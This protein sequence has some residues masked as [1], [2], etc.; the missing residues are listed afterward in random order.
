[1]TKRKKVFIT[2]LIVLILV[3]AGTFYYLFFSG[4]LGTLADLVTGPNER[5]VVSQKAQEIF[6]NAKSKINLQVKNDKLVLED[7]KK[8]G[9]L[10]GIIDVGDF[11]FI[12][13][14]LWEAEV[15]K[16]SQ[17]N[18]SIKTSTD[19]QTWSED[20][21]QVSQEDWYYINIRKP[22]SRIMYMVEFSK[23]K[24]T[25]GAD[26]QTVK[27]QSNIYLDDMNRDT[28]HRENEDGTIR[29]NLYAHLY[30]SGVDN[31][32]Y[33]GA[34]IDNAGMAS[35]KFTMILLTDKMAF[36]SPVLKTKTSDFNNELTEFLVG[37][38]IKVYFVDEA[39]TNSKKRIKG[40]ARLATR[41]W[42][43]DQ[44]EA[45]M[46]NPSR[47]QEQ[48]NYLTNI[49]DIS[50]K[51]SD[52]YQKLQIVEGQTSVQAERDKKEPDLKYL[53]SGKDKPNKWQRFTAFN[54]EAYQGKDSVKEL[55]NTSRMKYITK[56]QYIDVV[57]NDS[58][59]KLKVNDQLKGYYV[60]SGVN[61]GGKFS[62]IFYPIWVTN[63]EAW[64]GA[65]EY[66]RLM[67][68]IPCKGGGD[69]SLLAT[70]AL[71]QFGLDVFDDIE[72]YVADGVENLWG[73]DRGVG[74][75]GGV[76]DIPG[77]E[78]LSDQLDRE[79]FLNEGLNHIPGSAII[80]E[81]DG[82][83]IDN[84]DNAG[85]GLENPLPIPNSTLN[86]MYNIFRIVEASNPLIALGTIFAENLVIDIADDILEIFFGDGPEV[87]GL[88]TPAQASAAYN[89]LASVYALRGVEPTGGDSAEL[90]EAYEA[91]GDQNLQQLAIY[92]TV[93][94]EPNDFEYPIN[95]GDDPDIPQS[96][97]E[98]PA[99]IQLGA[100]SGYS[101]DEPDN[102]DETVD[103]GQ[104]GSADQI[105]GWVK[106]G[107]IKTGTD[108]IVLIVVTILVVVG[109]INLISLLRRREDIEDI[110]KSK[111]N[112]IE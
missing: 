103:Q 96:S 55:Q 59:A 36:V 97:E 29:Q 109:L 64:M 33:L 106:G 48:G 89:R 11:D 44:A 108:L 87:C 17:L 47:W 83:V 53:K 52:I 35:K 15:P 90:S 100:S 111:P 105:P 51:H 4:Q 75:H 6:D 3:L 104:S 112:T 60:G 7:G 25:Y 69:Y 81:Q 84:I 98:S 76:N 99:L 39:E 61:A 110:K 71:G 85:I 50:G 41:D 101:G 102:V 79:D 45:A 19:G 74:D 66:Q 67:F 57:A 24:L 31:G 8:R 9:L 82:Q 16:G 86:S 73:S 21:S 5:V 77:S 13:R 70:F 107:L 10:L 27:D 28:E 49:V 20:W 78:E 62:D 30:I 68:F 42:N 23:E 92:V 65:G 14:F 93:D 72:A 32:R 26:Q 38:D 18:V 88:L 95:D 56:N 12:R 54:T 2:S 63:N 94:E 80:G 46:V 91:F 1:M 37:G 34:A 22:V 58:N 43:S 40:E